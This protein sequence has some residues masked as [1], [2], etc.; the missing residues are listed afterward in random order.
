MRVGS[1]CIGKP[2]HACKECAFLHI[3]C[4]YARRKATVKD[5][6]DE[7]NTKA[8]GKPGKTTPPRRR[9]R[10]AATSFV[11]DPVPP[12]VEI[13]GVVPPITIPG[14]KRAR[15]RSPSAGPAQ[16]ASYSLDRG[17][18]SPDFARSL[19]QMAAD[20]GAMARSQAR[21]A[22][23]QERVAAAVERMLEIAEE[24]RA[25][26]D[27]KGKRTAWVGKW[28]PGADDDVMEDVRTATP[29]VF[30]QAPLE[31]IA[32]AGAS[33]SGYAGGMTPAREGSE[34]E[35]DD[36]AGG[37]GTGGKRPREEDEGEVEAKK[38]RGA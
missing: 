26:R 31:D 14:T 12:A 32:T 2:G 20:M 6:D 23:G 29:L 4:S 15:R 11:S 37:S 10:S 13:T 1:L 35:A 24:D 36:A 19:A 22:R 9:Q 7:D 30:E 33:G 25:G 3:G 16:A 8:Q 27:R 28:L 17:I 18:L 5:K 21:A 38:A 34:P